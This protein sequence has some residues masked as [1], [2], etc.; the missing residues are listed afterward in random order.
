MPCVIGVQA[1]S[2]K[3]SKRDRGSEI[4]PSYQH[5]ESSINILNQVLLSFQSTSHD[6]EQVRRST[7]W[8][9][10]IRDSSCWNATRL[11]WDARIL[12]DANAKLPN[13]ASAGGIRSIHSN[14]GYCDTF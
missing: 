13:T 5:L 4:P 2:G 10:G 7:I 8:I 14:S 6:P 1:T 11:W 12:C 9:A 3:G